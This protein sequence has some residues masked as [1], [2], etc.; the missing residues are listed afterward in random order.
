VS[1]PSEGLLAQLTKEQVVVNGLYAAWM[2]SVYDWHRVVVKE[3]RAESDTVVVLFVD[4]GDVD[5]LPASRLRRITPD[6]VNTPTFALRCALNDYSVEELD[7]QD[8]ALQ[9]NELVFIC[10]EEGVSQ[11]RKLTVIAVRFLARLF[12]DVASGSFLKQE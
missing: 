12:M 5:E 1:K 4:H 3:K 11:A 6:L 8:A 9:F 10:N 7:D 2:E